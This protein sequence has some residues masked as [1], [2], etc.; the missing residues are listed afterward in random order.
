MYTVHTLYT[1]FPNYPL[2][3]SRPPSVWGYACRREKEFFLSMNK[4]VD[5]SNPLVF[6]TKLEM[7]GCKMKWSLL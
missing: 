1:L 5:I 6:S 3:C 4:V 2:S 7:D